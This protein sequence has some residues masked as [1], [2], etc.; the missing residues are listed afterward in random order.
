M[1]A[2]FVWKNIG[3]GES[4]ARA[5][6]FSNSGV[7][8]SLVVGAI[9]FWTRRVAVAIVHLRNFAGDVSDRCQL[10]V[11]SWPLADLNFSQFLAN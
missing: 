5:N 4:A 10:T 1:G 7:G 2:G 8:K 6:Y 3:I 11:R 9:R